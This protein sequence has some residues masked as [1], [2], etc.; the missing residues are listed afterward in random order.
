MKKILVGLAGVFLVVIAYIGSNILQAA[1]TFT[2]LSPMGANTCERVDVFPGT[3]DVTIDPATGMVFVSADDRRGNRTDDAASIQGGIYAFHIDDT[4]NVIKVSTDAPDDFHPHGISF[5]S[6][7]D[8]VNAGAKRLMVIN[9]KETGEQNVEIFD[10]GDAGALTHIESVA[11]KDMTSPND[12][13]AVG[14]SAFYATNDRGYREGIMASLEAYLAL[15]LASAVF[16][17]GLE[18]GIAVKGLKF[19]NGI[20]VSPDGN[21]VYIAEVLRR[22]V[23]VYERHAPTGRLKFVKSIKVGTGPDNIEIAEDGTLWIAGHPKIFD[24]LAHAEDASKNSPTQ[25]ISVNPVTDGVKQEI[26]LLNGE[27][28]AAS[29]AA[30]YGNKV[31]VGAVF[32]EHVMV[33]EAE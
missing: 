3:E 14:P 8:G 18:G 9:H 21:T 19:A 15:P 10:V 2:D 16:Y 13:V 24:F 30:H 28:N 6:G 32:D 11:F 26:V 17:D 29:V 25:V 27:I 4:E 20:N 7:H 1:G 23:G 22:S 33:C 31:V 5:W 12:L